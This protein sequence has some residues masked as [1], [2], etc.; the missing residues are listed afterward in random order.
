M[1][2]ITGSVAAIILLLGVIG[3]AEHVELVD[4]PGTSTEKESAIN[5][6]IIITFI[7]GITLLGLTHE[8]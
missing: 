7:G 5:F 6:C 1:K 3:L 8:N 2:I 4:V